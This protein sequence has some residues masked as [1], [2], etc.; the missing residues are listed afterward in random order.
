MINRIWGHVASVT[1]HGVIDYVG[2][3][4]SCTNTI[5]RQNN[6]VSRNKITRRK[7]TMAGSR[8]TRSWVEG[9]HGVTGSK[10]KTGTKSPRYT[11]LGGF[12]A[13]YKHAAYNAI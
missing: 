7:N 9:G 1:G 5:T 4:L 13:D 11:L 3:K 6:I 10:V 2:I 8:V 12:A